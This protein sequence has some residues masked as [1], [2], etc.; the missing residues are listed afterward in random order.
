MA[1]GRVEK[2]PLSRKAE[3]EG[4][5]EHIVID[6]SYAN[7]VEPYKQLALLFSFLTL[8]GVGKSRQEAR[9]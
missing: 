6:A 7:M 5:R 9:I 1:R 4:E 2:L 3:R 8:L